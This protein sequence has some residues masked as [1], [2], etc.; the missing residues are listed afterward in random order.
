MI[1]FYILLLNAEVPV[2]YEEF[3]KKRKCRTFMLLTFYKH[4]K[5]YR[6]F[7]MDFS[8]IRFVWHYKKVILNLIKDF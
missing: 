4:F 7:S 8:C 2:R 1:N 3:N 6:L 5:K